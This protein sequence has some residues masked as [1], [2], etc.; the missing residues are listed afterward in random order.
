MAKRLNRGY[1]WWLA[2]QDGQ[3]TKLAK[4]FSR[5]LRPLLARYNGLRASLAHVVGKR[6]ELAINP[7]LRRTVAHRIGIREANGVTLWNSQ[8]RWLIIKGQTSLPAYPF[9]V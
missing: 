9:T 2:A 3:R 5:G 6:L 8:R 4:R 7:G 1:R